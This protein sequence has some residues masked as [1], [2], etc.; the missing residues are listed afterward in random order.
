[1]A[2]KKKKTKP[3]SNK[4]KA[5]TAQK[6]E[7]MYQVFFKNGTL[8]SVVRE[9]T[10]CKRTAMKYKKADNWE[11]RVEETKRKAVKQVDNKNAVQLVK[12]LDLAKYTLKKLMQE[13]KD[14]GVESKSK[15]HDLDKL[16]R[17]IEFLSGSP[18]SR[19]EIKDPESQNI[20][21]LEK[22]LQQLEEQLKAL[23]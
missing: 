13:I 16:L 22:S 2:K 3:K 1:M 15:V 18:D 8:L 14:D 20:E 4:G 9:C 6:R 5:L 19:P 23:G 7:K 12:S 11:H 10:V 21:E 17:L